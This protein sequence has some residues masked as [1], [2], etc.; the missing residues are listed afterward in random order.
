MN[1]ATSGQLRPFA[2]RGVLLVLGA[3]GLAACAPWRTA[4]IP[5][6]QIDDRLENGRGSEHLVVFLPGAYDEPQDFIRFGFIEE[7]RQRR[8]AADAIVIDSH[9][10]YFND[11]SIAERIRDDVL[12]PARTRGYR[13]IWMVGISLGGLGSLLTAERYPGITG[14]VA[15]APY[16]GTRAAFEEVRRAGGLLQWRREGSTATNE[17]ERRLLGWL[18]KGRDGSGSAGADLILGYGQEDR[19]ADTLSE[20]AKVIEPSRVFVRP[21]GHDWDTWRA[22]WRQVLD[23][24]AAVLAP[25]LPRPA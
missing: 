17:W 16:V 2:R 3:L 6:K 8:L 22:L 21:G 15:L 24:H 10:G 5:M 18:G 23:V 4:S 9:L 25:S 19:F 12:E 11:F 7:L 20:V 13:S 14:I 1:P